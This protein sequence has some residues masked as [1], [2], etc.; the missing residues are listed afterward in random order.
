MFRR[1]LIIRILGTELQ[2]M[3]ISQTGYDPEAQQSRLMGFV[4]TE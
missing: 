1:R 2:R 4:R 3:A